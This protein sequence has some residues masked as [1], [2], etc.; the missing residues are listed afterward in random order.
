MT[1]INYATGNGE[2]V[3]SV[4][5]VPFFGHWF[6][7]VLATKFAGVLYT[8][9]YRVFN[10]ERYF[11]AYEFHRPVLVLRDT[12]LIQDVLVKDFS[13]FSDHPNWIFDDRTFLRYSVL[14]LNGNFWRAVRYKFTP[15]FTGN[16][17]DSAF[18]RLLKTAPI[19]IEE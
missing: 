4:H 10:K 7:V 17:M 13:H 18:K 6:P 2:G 19:K 15:S 11:G 1:R 14:R 8:E 5:A 12:K 9:M 3:K 16:T